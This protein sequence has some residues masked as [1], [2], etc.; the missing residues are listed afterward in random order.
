MFLV[1]LG[2]SHALEIA[3][4]GGWFHHSNCWRNQLPEPLDPNHRGFLPSS[5]SE[6]VSKLATLS[7][8]VPYY[9]PRETCR[10]RYHENIR[11]LV[12]WLI[13]V[14]IVVKVGGVPV[15]ITIG[16]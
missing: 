16:G 1:I 15:T 14:V 8:A 9:V 2:E 7:E 4:S 5:V 3:R 12:I 10:K 13:V 6:I 11:I